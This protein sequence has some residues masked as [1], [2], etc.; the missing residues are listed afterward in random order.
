MMGHETK[1]TP[2]SIPEWLR[3]DN[4]MKAQFCELVN[5]ALEVAPHMSLAKFASLLDEALKEEALMK[6]E[7]DV[8]RQLK[9]VGP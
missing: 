2:I 1:A 8:E 7:A 9:E 5:F 4:P 6:L 3:A